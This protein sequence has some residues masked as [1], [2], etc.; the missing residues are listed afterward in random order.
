MI[1]SKRA[2]LLRSERISWVFSTW[3]VCLRR[4]SCRNW[5]RV[6]RSLGPNSAAESSRISLTVM[7]GGSGGRAFA[8]DEAAAEGEFGIGQPEGLFCD[9][10]RDPG[11]VEEDRA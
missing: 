10:G 6:S 5:S 3:P 4:C 11:G 7:G 9:P 8:D 1:V 2:T